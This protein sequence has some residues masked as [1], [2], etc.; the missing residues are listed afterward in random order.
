M[1][2]R[3]LAGRMTALVLLVSVS[4][5]ACAQSPSASSVQTPTSDTQRA[6]AP[7]ATTV[8]LPRATSP[9]PSTSSPSAISTNAAT[10]EPTQIPMSEPSPGPATTRT[11][12]STFSSGG[13]GLTR[14]EWDIHHEP[15]TGDQNT[16]SYDQKT[17]RVTFLN[18]TVWSLT[19]LWDTAGVAL[20]DARL[21]GKALIPADSQFVQTY[22]DQD[23]R[24]V[25]VYHSEALK[26]R[27]PATIEV[28][29]STVSAW[30]GGKPGDCIVI[31]N[32]TA[33]NSSVT[34]ISIAIG[35]SP[36]SVQ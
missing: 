29:G 30:P 1:T 31:Y 16:V 18:G 6:A 21:A 2:N 28:G 20:D 15:D 33:G 24:T 19:R 12:T 25:D 10:S 35:N 36:E 22:T 8:T 11:A 4:V 23:K 27:F 7:A 34:S 17:Y 32:Q 13:L 9:L 14:T 26:G 3:W 5:V